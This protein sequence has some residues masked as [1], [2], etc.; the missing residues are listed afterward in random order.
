MKSEQLPVVNPQG[1]DDEMLELLL[2]ET[3][4]YFHHEINLQTGLLADT[5]RPGSYSSIAAVGMGLSS[6][7]SA[8][9]RGL[10]S[11]EEAI[12]RTL[13]VLKFF[14]SSKQGTEVDASGYKGF[15]YHFLDMITGKRVEKC[16]LSR[17]KRDSQA[18]GGALFA[19]RL[20]MGS[21]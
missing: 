13:T 4:K 11:R 14:H 1:T 17:R 21:K 6:Y 5:T 20:A 3:F 19:G 15:Y 16:E 10:V 18:C 7:I 2:S 12:K 8:V 9:E